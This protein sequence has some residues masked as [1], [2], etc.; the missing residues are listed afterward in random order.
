MNIVKSMMRFFVLY[1]R[2]ETLKAAMYIMNKIS[3]KL[4]PSTPFELWTSR[5]LSLKHLYVW[6]CPKIIICLGLIN[7]NKSL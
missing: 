2:G 4:V 7:T 3:S 5:K 6:S 1:L